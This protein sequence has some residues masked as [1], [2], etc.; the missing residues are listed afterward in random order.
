MP[1]RR[2]KGPLFNPSLRRLGLQ[3]LAAVAAV[4]AFT[5]S[6]AQ[7][8]D[9]FAGTS[10]SQ[11]KEV[12]VVP[13]APIV[14]SVPIA[15]PEAEATPLETSSKSSPNVS[16]PWDFHTTTTR[17]TYRAFEGLRT[18]YRVH[19]IQRP[20]GSVSGRGELWAENDVEVEGLNHLVMKLD[21]HVHDGV[22]HLSFEIAA[23]ARTTTG[24]ATLIFEN[25]LQRW[26]GSFE[27]SSGASSGTALLTL[28]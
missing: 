1:S 16:G 10:D 23:R 5:A 8:A 26:Q 4:A 15:K 28:R 25:E 11:E 12:I 17:T 27:S 7:I 20:D 19:L 3:L 2:V 13:A 21:G 14:I 9:Y 6:L 22:L 24:S 18:H